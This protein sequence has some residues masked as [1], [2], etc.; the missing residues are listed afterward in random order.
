M[1]NAR[2]ALVLAGV[3]LLLDH[4]RRARPAAPIDDP[5]FGRDKALHF[6]AS[7]SLAVVGLRRA[8]RWRPMTG[9]PASRRG[10]TFALGVGTAQGS[11]GLT[12]H[13]DASWRDLTWDV[14]GT[15]TGVLFAYAID[16]AIGRLRGPSP[17]GAGPDDRSR[18]DRSSN[19]SGLLNLRKQGLKV[20]EQSRRFHAVRTLTGGHQSDDSAEQTTTAVRWPRR[21]PAPRS[22]RGPRAVQAGEEDDLQREI[23]TQ[24][25]SVADLERL[26]ELK[27]TG[28]EITQ[29][30]SWLDEAWS[31]RS[32]HEYDQ[33]R[34]VLERTRKQA[35]LIRA[36]ITASKL[37]AQAT[38][39]RRAGGPARAKIA[40]TKKAL[41]DTMKRRSRSEGGAPSAAT[42]WR[43]ATSPPAATSRRRAGKPAAQPQG[44]GASGAPRRRTHHEDADDRAPNRRGPAAAGAA[45]GLRDAAQAERAGGLRAAAPGQ[46][47]ARGQQEVARSGRER[48]EARR[49]FARGMAVERPGRSRA[50]TPSWRTS[51]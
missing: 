45:R 48:R 22:A 3:A 24:R 38:R 37:R 7:A 18:D 1:R 41:A 27:A 14:V 4:I 11:L 29:L 26:D 13:G 34:E 20:I 21:S 23:D 10:V 31:L 16:W 49:P 44:A 5:W 17:G 15:T 39:A 42:R 51:S 12:G 47:P 40:R 6:A 43:P 8:P 50:A 19:A 36:K 2:R 33:V 9:P 28:D 30:R 25:V 35:D 32:K 46:Q